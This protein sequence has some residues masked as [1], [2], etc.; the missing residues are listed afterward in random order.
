MRL[1]GSLLSP[2]FA[3]L[4]EHECPRCHREVELP[5][6]DLC[7]ACE[8]EINTRAGRVARWVSLVTMLVF[9]IYATAVLPL[10]RTARMVGAAATVAWYLIVRRVTLQVARQWF[11]SR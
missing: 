7:A 2:S 6:G 9:G 11:L 3:G 8:R 10:D 1:R 5:L 4:R